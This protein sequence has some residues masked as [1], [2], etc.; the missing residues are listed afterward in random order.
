M[1]GDS[2][3]G[4]IYEKFTRGDKIRI[5]GEVTAIDKPITKLSINVWNPVHKE[6]HPR[7]NTTPDYQTF[8]SYSLDNFEID[9]SKSV[10]SKAD[11]LLLQCYAKVEGGVGAIHLF[12]M[13]IELEEKTEVGITDYSPIRSKVI[14]DNESITLDFDAYGKPKL[15]RMMIFVD[16][17]IEEINNVPNSSDYLRHNFDGSEYGVGRHLVEFVAVSGDEKVRREITIEVQKSKY[18]DSISAT[19][20]SERVK[21]GDSGSINVKASYNDGDTETITSQCSYESMNENIIKVYSTGEFRILKDYGDEVKVKVCYGDFN[22]TIRIF[23]DKK[24]PEIEEIEAKLDRSK[25]EKGDTGLITVNALYDNGDSKDVTSQCNYENMNEDILK[26]YSSGKFNVLEDYGD[27]VKVKIRYDEFND[28]VNVFVEKRVPTD[29]EVKADKSKYKVGEE[30]KIDVYAI[31]SEGEKIKVTSESLLTSSD[32]STIKV[33]SKDFHVKDS[34]SKYVTLSASY[35]GLNASIEV[36]VEP[37]I[38]LDKIILEGFDEKLKEGDIG[39]YK[40]V[41]EYSDGSQKDVTEEANA[42]S[43]KVGTLELN[44]GRYKVLK[45]DSDDIKIYVNYMGKK[46]EK[47]VLL[48]NVVFEKLSVEFENKVYEE[49]EEGSLKVIAHF[50]DGTEKVV[51]KECTFKSSDDKLIKVFSTGDFIVQSTDKDSASISIEVDVLGQKRSA[52]QK[53]DIKKIEYESIEVEVNGDKKRVEVGETISYTVYGITKKNVKEDITSKCNLVL[54]SSFIQE[55]G[56]GMLRVVDSS[57]FNGI[58]NEKIKFVVGDFSIEKTFMLLFNKRFVKLV[59]RTKSNENVFT[60]GQTVELKAYAEFT[61]RTVKDVT[62]YCTFETTVGYGARITESRAIIDHNSA[63][64]YIKITGAYPGINQDAY[65]DVTLTISNGSEESAGDI[66]YR[67]GLING[68]SKTEKV[69]NEEGKMTRAMIVKL[70]VELMGKIEDSEK[71]NG[72]SRF[73][74]VKSEQWYFKYVNYANMKGWTSGV[75]GGKFN[76]NGQVSYQQACNFMLKALGYTDKW[77]TAE[78]FAQQKKIETIVTDKASLNRGE[79][80]ELM[81]DTLKAVKKGGK[82][83]FGYEVLNIEEFKGIEITGNIN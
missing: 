57:S 39:Y 43:S 6:E 15:D 77:T 51:T 49:D 14:K 12:T 27:E 21:V 38:I 17:K 73:N 47:Y 34:N 41:V 5:N 66:L 28:E 18:I 74:D 42:S 19:T 22:D 69:L 4:S 80:F 16:E 13:N 54:S 48:E 71:Y 79:G 37:K 30:G 8:S 24:E 62:E 67:L 2:S 78:T 44:K 45:I 70:L 65:S 53:I 63:S 61:D 64:N 76:P 46:A 10:F 3:N 55:A 40:V 20:R 1:S 82:Y 52:T 31:F 60:K 29:I 72:A 50:N 25:Y 35:E 23:V 33:Y 32:V 58:R 81:L 11:K 7:V 75:G 56:E 68:M 36:E 9:T 83:P 59:I 26:V